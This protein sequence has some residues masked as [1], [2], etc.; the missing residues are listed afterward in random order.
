MATSDFWQRASS[1]FASAR[2]RA[3]DSRVS[4][5]R[6]ARSAVKY[7]MIVDAM[8]VLASAVVAVLMVLYLLPVLG[9][10]D[11][12]HGTLFRGHSFA[13]HLTIL[14]GFIL[15]LLVASQRLNLYDPARLGGFL[16]EQ[17]LSVQACLVAGLLLM[18]S[19]YLIH[20]VKVP[21]SV[22]LVTLGLAT[23]SLSLRRLVY[24][25]LLHRK[26]DRGIDTRNVLI[27]GTGPAARALRGQLERIRHL[28]YSFK[29]FVALPSA[30]AERTAGGKDVAGSLEVLFPLVRQHF[31]DEIF[32]ATRCEG[33]VMRELVEESRAYGVDLRLV[34]D[35]YDG[36]TSW[37]SSIEYIGKFPTIPL[38]RSQASELGR[39]VKR[40][41]DLT[42]CSVGLVLLAPFFLL[43]AVLI[44]LDSPG[45]VFYASDRIGKKGRVFRC[46]KF[47]TM[48]E[49]AEGR[50]ADLMYMN[51]RDGVLFKV[52]NDPRV[53]RVG[54]FLRKFSLDELPQFFNVLRG[55]MS[56]V[57]PRPPVASEVKQY[58]LDHLRRLDVIPGI[59]GLWQV[60]A[61][62]DPSFDSYVSW[63][64]AYIEGWSIWLDLKIMVRTVGVVLSGT[65]T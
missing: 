16:H 54:H 2:E 22:V 40:I 13:L 30:D 45:P 8:T 9:A 23:A 62:H 58:K 35:N 3:E 46:F 47:R 24:R 55:D 38:H 49:D 25:I 59:T 7:W 36:M 37:N 6:G 51:E 64:I 31:V 26:F 21:R 41:F 53:T 57:G 39:L 15:A 18:G 63:D 28:G 29:G 11:F 5:V 1:R 17:R 27:V 32:V 14:A 43:M 61:R 44:K 10:H 65:G 50:K 20:S 42:F 56:V 12:Y 52:S 60:E 33:A 34:P 48:V 4:A 19:L